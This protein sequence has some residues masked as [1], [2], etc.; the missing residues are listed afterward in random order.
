MAVWPC[1]CRLPF[2]SPNERMMESWAYQGRRAVLL[3]YWYIIT[4]GVVELLKY[5]R[6]EQKRAAPITQLSRCREGGGCPRATRIVACLSDAVY[7]RKIAR[8]SLLIRST[9]RGICSNG[10]KSCC[11]CAHVH[12]QSRYRSFGESRET[13]GPQQVIDSTLLRA[14]SNKSVGGKLHAGFCENQSGGLGQQRYVCFLPGQASPQQTSLINDINQVA[15]GRDF[16][17]LACWPP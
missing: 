6:T 3:I 14:T 8:I 10:G 15:S 9:P 13:R 11:R 1:S 2:M 16:H 12:V 5:V 17:F 7:M 4:I